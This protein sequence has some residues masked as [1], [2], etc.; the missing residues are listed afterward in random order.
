MKKNA[1]FTLIELLVW[2]SLSVI[3]MVSVWVFVTSWMKNITLQ[4]QVLDNSLQVGDFYEKL[5]NIFNNDFDYVWMYSSWIL[6]KSKYILWSGD[7]TYLWVKTMTWECVWEPDLE[8]KYL[9]MHDFSP[10]EWDSWDLFVNAY[11]LWWITTDFFNNILK[12]WTNTFSWTFKNI[13]WIA[14]NWNDIYVADSL[15]SNI[16]KLDKTN[17]SKKPELIVGQNMFWDYFSSW[18]VWT[19]IYLNNPSGLAYWDWKLFIADSWNN[20]I[21]YLSW[22]LVYPLL[23]INDNIYNP[24]WLYYDSSEKKL[25]ISNSWNNEILTY[26]FADQLKNNVNLDF[27][28]QNSINFNKI[29]ILLSSW[30][31]SWAYSKND[32]DFTWF[33]TDPWDTW[34]WAWNKFTYNFLNPQNLSSWVIWVK[35]ISWTFTWSIYQTINFY[36]SWTLVKSIY[37]PF[38]TVWDWEITTKTDNL[39]QTFVTWFSYPTWIYKNWTDIIVNDF[40]WRAYLKYDTSWN[41]I[42]SWS[43][44]SFDFD[45]KNLKTQNFKIKTF[46]SNIE[47]NTI[48]IK[49]EYYKNF[50]CYDPTQN[51]LKTIIYKKKLN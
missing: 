39:L 24:K 28:F 46:V 44:S 42:S 51:I 29:E 7:F 16:Y 17:T 12:S 9:V 36:N 31:L 10:F 37:K 35:N 47:N 30:S 3:L 18:A 4:K 8:T 32:F 6:L 49:I 1:W 41:L 45:N 21:I 50:S 23:D 38:F 2:V 43:L 25:Y 40:I 19:W 11:N 20:R 13:S 22:G 34:R 26:S 27:T 48:N 15:S 14:Q 33:S 5:W